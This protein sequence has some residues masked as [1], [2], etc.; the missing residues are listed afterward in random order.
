MGFDKESAP[1]LKNWGKVVVDHKFIIR[2]NEL[3]EIAGFTKDC[4]GETTLTVSL[5]LL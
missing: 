4:V 2:A 3:E 1:Y 5:T